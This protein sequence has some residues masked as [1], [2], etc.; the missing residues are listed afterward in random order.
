MINLIY[1][2]GLV[3]GFLTLT[4]PKEAYENLQDW[5]ALVAGWL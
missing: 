4:P 3:F 5:W 2:G 1:R